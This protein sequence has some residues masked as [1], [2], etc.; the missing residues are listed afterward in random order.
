MAYAAPVPSAP[1]QNS[2]LPS[3]SEEAA[4]YVGGSYSSCPAMWVPPYWVN[5]TNASLLVLI[6]YNSYFNGAV[7]VPPGQPAIQACGYTLYPIGAFS[8]NP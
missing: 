7:L 1:P 2:G 4:Y 6:G 5:N 8:G 3:A